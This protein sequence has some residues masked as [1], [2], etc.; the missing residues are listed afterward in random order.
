MGTDLVTDGL[1]GILQ[2]LWEAFMIARVAGIVIII[3][4][5]IVGFGVGINLIGK[6]YFGQEQPIIPRFTKW[7]FAQVSKLIPVLG[8]CIMDYLNRPKPPKKPMTMKRKIASVA[9]I[10]VYFLALTGL[11]FFA[12]SPNVTLGTYGTAEGGVLIEVKAT[13]Y[14]TDG[15]AFNVEF[16][17]PA[18]ILG[19]WTDMPSYQWESDNFSIKNGALVDF[20]VDNQELSYNISARYPF[21]TPARSVFVYFEAEEPDVETLKPLKV[22]WNGER[23]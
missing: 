13:R 16:D 19:I 14:P 7:L 23:N 11:I 6:H 1:G 8:G 2:Q 21:A 12:S 22:H 17:H 9:L 15:F 10:I 5:A 4:F 3:I 18:K 20:Q